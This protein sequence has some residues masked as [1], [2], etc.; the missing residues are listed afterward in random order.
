MLCEQVRMKME[1]S[2][3]QRRGALSRN[4]SIKILPG[5]EQE[6]GAWNHRHRFTLMSREQDAANRD[7]IMCLWADTL[8][9][10][11]AHGARF[12]AHLRPFHPD[13]VSDSAHIISILLISF[14]FVPAEG[15]TIIFWSNLQ[16]H[17]RGPTL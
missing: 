17:S 4:Q 9:P 3:A 2:C 14:P 13:L 1:G 5:K 12:S 10:P 8:P 16:K 11:R 7:G 6:V 15:E